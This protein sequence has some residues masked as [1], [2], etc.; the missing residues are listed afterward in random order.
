MLLFLAK[1]S[2]PTKWSQFHGVGLIDVFSKWY[3]G[4]LVVCARRHKIPTFVSKAMMMAYEKGRAPVHVLLALGVLTRR[5]TEW[6]SENE[7]LCI[8]GGDVLQAFDHLRWDSSVDALRAH[9]IPMD[10]VIA[11]ANESLENCAGPSFEE[12]GVGELP[13]DKCVRTGGK[14]SAWI[15]NSAFRYFLRSLVPGWEDMGWGSWWEAS[16][17]RILSL[18]TTSGCWLLA[19]NIWLGWCALFL[20]SWPV[21]GCLGRI[22]L[23]SGFGHGRLMLAK[24][25]R[26]SARTALVFTS[27]LLRR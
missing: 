8:F 15:W 6:R 2:N 23:L 25:W 27:R 1:E 12:L 14:E 18:L 5:F 17:S 21:T 26:L 11:L 7:R 16:G 22:N 9:G 10:V 24:I 4:S 20:M 13:Y 19:G 3:C